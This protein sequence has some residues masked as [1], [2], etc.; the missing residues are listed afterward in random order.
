V[1]G[2]GGKVCQ[3][4]IDSSLCGVIGDYC[5]EANGETDQSCPPACPDEI[6]TTA[7]DCIYVEWPLD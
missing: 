7:Q 1:S 2:T 3:A 4:K 6:C 5:N